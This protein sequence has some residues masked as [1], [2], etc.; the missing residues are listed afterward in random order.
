MRGKTERIDKILE[1]VLLKKGITKNIQLNK[2]RTYEEI[3]KEMDYIIREMKQMKNSVQD[4]N[5]N[6][7]KDF[8][9]INNLISNI[10]KNIKNNNDNLI[11]SPEIKLITSSIAKFRDLELLTGKIEQL[12]NQFLVSV[13]LLFLLD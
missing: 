10:T 7:L 1:S 13:N 8:T 3:Q 4:I 2:I 5:E 11:F 6:N 12:I 9:K